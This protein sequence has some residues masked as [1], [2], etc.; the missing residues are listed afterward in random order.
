MT[1]NKLARL[2]GGLLLLATGTIVIG[3]VPSHAQGNYSTAHYSMAGGRGTLPNDIDAALVNPALLAL[4]GRHAFSF[5]LISGS[6]H[7]DQNV[8]SIARWNS[9][10]GTF[11][12]SHEKTQ[13]LDS[14]GDFARVNALT[15]A[16]SLGIQIGPFAIGAYHILD[17]E[18]RLPKDLFELVLNGNQFNRTYHFGDFGINSESVSVIHASYGFKLPMAA[19]SYIPMTIIPVRQLYGGIGLKYYMGHQY[20]RIEDGLVDLTFTESGLFGNA[21]YSYRSAGIPGSQVDDDSDDPEVIADSTFSGIAGSG[22]GLD[23]GIA[24]VINDQVSFHAGLLNLSTGISWNKSTYNILLTASADTIG[25][26][27]TWELDDEAEQTDLDSLTTSE[28]DVTKTGSFKTP[29][30]VLLRMGTTLRYKRTTFNI[31]IEQALTRG[32]GYNLMPRL[33]LGV[34]WRPLSIFPLR[35]GMSLGGRHGLVGAIGFGLDLRALVW[36]FGIANTGLTPGGIKGI[37]VSSGLK[38]SF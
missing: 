25:I 10:Q 16:S 33:G 31:E 14:L 11:L 32:M 3:P 17:V 12:D 19:E 9:W 4:P 1:C 15:E 29:V 22:F 7:I 8:M 28:V 21:F 34:E 38:I 35:A 30:P 2:A 27:T 20:A 24:G 37:G 13:F 6:A 26:G 18:A 5:R 36:D 23:L